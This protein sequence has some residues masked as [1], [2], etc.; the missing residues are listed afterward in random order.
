V[1]YKDEDMA[2]EK[3]EVLLFGMVC[4]PY[5]HPKRKNAFL[6]SERYDEHMEQYIPKKLRK[7]RA[8]TFFF[9]AT[10]EKVRYS[11]INA[12]NAAALLVAAHDRNVVMVSSH[13]LGLGRMQSVDDLGK[14]EAAASSVK[15]A[16][17]KQV[18][19]HHPDKGGCPTKFRCL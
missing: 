14:A 3:G 5:D 1:Y 16:Y 19:A 11:W 9:T 8:R 13:H 18:V 7:K 12:L 10:D 2:V 17:R 4:K 15:K 6:L